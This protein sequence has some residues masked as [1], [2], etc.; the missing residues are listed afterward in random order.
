MA[1]RIPKDQLLFQCGFHLKLSSGPCYPRGFEGEDQKRNYCL[2]GSV[3][4]DL[5][6]L[7]VLRFQELVF[8]M[9]D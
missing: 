5:L 1:E 8:L 3:M 2:A 6:M 4:G 9:L 7:L